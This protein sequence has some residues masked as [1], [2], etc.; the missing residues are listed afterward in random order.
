MMISFFILFHLRAGI[1]DDA[2]GIVG[3]HVLLE[4]FHGLDGGHAP[5]GG[6]GGQDFHK[7][8]ALPVH[9]FFKGLLDGALGFVDVGN[10]G[11]AHPLGMNL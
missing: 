7:G 3:N 4:P 1:L 11:D 10:V 9:L 6:A 2:Q 5:V 8:E